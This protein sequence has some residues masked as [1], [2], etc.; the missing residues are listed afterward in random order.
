MRFRKSAPSDRREHDGR[1]SARVVWDVSE[2]GAGPRL[3]GGV[4]TIERPGVWSRAA[5]ALMVGL[6]MLGVAKASTPLRPSL[7]ARPS[8]MSALPSKGTA[9]VIA[10]GCTHHDSHNDKTM[11]SLG[12]SH[13]DQ[14]GDLSC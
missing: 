10:A 1:P 3:T 4:F 11:Q 14:H 2:G 6:S 9:T 12:G 13:L 8:D 5:A 7:S